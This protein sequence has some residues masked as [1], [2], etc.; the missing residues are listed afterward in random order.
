MSASGLASRLSI[1]QEVSM[2]THT[3]RI[4]LVGFALVA[5]ATAGANTT[6]HSTHS[7]STSSVNTGAS[8]TNTTAGANAAAAMPKSDAE[9]AAILEAA[10]TA[11]IE[12]ARMA[13]SQA[14]NSEV[15]SFA[16]MMV[17]EHSKN[18]SKGDALLGRLKIKP[19]ETAASR[20]LKMR[21]NSKMDAL[22]DKSGAEFDRAY[23]DTQVQMHQQVATD[24]Q[25]KLIPAAKNS[26]F[27][28]FLQETLSH[29]QGHLEQAQRLQSQVA[30]GSSAVNPGSGTGTGTMKK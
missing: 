28:S 4:I 2:S 26:E 5:G 18:D 25:T 6:D 17:T 16:Q 30:S 15:K 9:I 24:L 19:S 13:Q 10:N 22:K 29:V 20:D 23:M 27:R 7:G 8:T 3:Y 14:S 11:E 1:K 21:S 12:T